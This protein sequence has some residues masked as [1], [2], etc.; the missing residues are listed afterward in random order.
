LIKRQ[1]SAMRNI[2]PAPR[3]ISFA[4]SALTSFGIQPKDPRRTAAEAYLRS[5][6]LKLDDDLVD[7]VLRFHAHCPWRNEDTGLT[8]I[9]ALLAAF[10]SLDDDVITGVHRIRLDQPQYWPKAERRMLGIV[11]RAAV[12]F[13]AGSRDLIIGQGVETCMTARHAAVSAPLRSSAVAASRCRV[14]QAPESR[15][16]E[17]LLS[18]PIRRLSSTPCFTILCCRPVAIQ[19]SWL[20]LGSIT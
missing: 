7:T 18:F 1:W 13:D 3:T 20:A 15:L 5:R 6:A 4:S 10:R 17:M 19:L 2:G 16:V 12:K 8:E 14:L 11:R 9:P